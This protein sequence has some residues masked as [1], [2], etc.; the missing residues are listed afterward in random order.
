MKYSKRLIF[1]TLTAL[2]LI[3]GCGP[4]EEERQRRE[5]AREDSLEQ[6]RRQ[7]LEQ[8]RLDSLEKAQSAQQKQQPAANN[9]AGITFSDDGPFAVQ[10]E[11]WRSE[12]KAQQAAEK[13]KERGFNNTTV[14][15]YGD[16]QRGDVWFRVRLG[17][18]ESR[19]AAEIIQQ[20]LHE[21][22]QTESW[23]APAE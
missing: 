14:V 17:R 21:E 18:L 19:Q 8:Q 10:V 7:E 6:V 9:M 2:L 1:C 15:Q 11:S 13:W 3:N 4:D 12:Y 20:N 22:Y 23:I 16:A 5:Q